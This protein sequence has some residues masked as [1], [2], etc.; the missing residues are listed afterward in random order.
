LQ[1][2]AAVNALGREVSPA[3]RGVCNGRSRKGHGWFRV[4]GRVGP[5]APWSSVKHNWLL[6]S[7][8]ICA[9]PANNK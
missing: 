7:I 6:A 5:F 9:A 2:E 3:G 8:F 4:L 1:A